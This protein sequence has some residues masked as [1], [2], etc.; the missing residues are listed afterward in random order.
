MRVLIAEDDPVIA[1]GLEAKLAALGHHVV[2]RVA[3][4]RRAVEEAAR[5]RPDA[6]VMDVVMQGLDGLEAAC[7]IAQAR[8]VPI[9]AITAHDQPEYLERAIR[10]GVAAYLVKPVDGR[11]SSGPFVSPSPATPNSKRC[12]ARSTASRKHSKPAGSWNGPRESSWTVSVS[13]R[14]TPSSGSSTGPATPTARWPTSPANSST[15]RPSSSDQ[16]SGDAGSRSAGRALQLEPASRPAGVAGDEVG[17]L[18]RSS[19]GLGDALGEPAV[20]LADDFGGGR[21]RRLE[22][23]VVEDQ[24]DGIPPFDPARLEASTGGDDLEAVD[25]IFGAGQRRPPTPGRPPRRPREDY[26]RSAAPR[27]ASRTD[28]RTGLGIPQSPQVARAGRYWSRGRP[29]PVDGPTSSITR[30]A[31]Q[32]L[33]RC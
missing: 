20:E 25:G 19:G 23:A 1:L 24:V 12:A 9:L 3:D 21:G 16:A 8:P 14:R 18:D 10:C 22:R 7:A 33:A 2:A 32:S 17:D 26:A 15:R 6:V 4:G 30:P 13:P 29:R 27:R 11:R 28:A 31:S 5:T